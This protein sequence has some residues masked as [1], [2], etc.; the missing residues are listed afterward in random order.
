MKRK[1]MKY[2]RRDCFKLCEQDIINKLFA[3]YLL[4]LPKID[5]DNLQ[6]CSSLISIETNS[7]ECVEKCP[8]ECDMTTY[9][10]SISYAEYPSSLEMTKLSDY[11]YLNE[12]ILELNQPN[13]NDSYSLSFLSLE[14]ARR[15]LVKIFVYFDEIKYTSITESPTISFVD[16]IAGIGGTL[17]LFIGISLL[18]FVEV[19]ELIFDMVSVLWSNLRNKNY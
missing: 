9:E 2:R 1:G 10:L 6:P 16:L 14:L 17:G 19:I 5:D 4:N 15:S 13:R 11:I 3:C 7:T 8:H 18:S 12:T